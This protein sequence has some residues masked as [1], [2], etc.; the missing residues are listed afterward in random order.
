MKLA[1]FDVFCVFQADLLIQFDFVAN[2]FPCQISERQEPRA[3]VSPADGVRTIFIFRKYHSV[4]EDIP[5]PPV[6]VVDP[7]KLREFIIAEKP[8]IC[9]DF[10]RQY[11]AAVEC[12]ENEVV[13][14]IIKTG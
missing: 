8:G 2:R 11:Q 6:Q 3:V 9:I 13:F 10:R 7:G 4:H 12:L 14:P 5:V 1:E